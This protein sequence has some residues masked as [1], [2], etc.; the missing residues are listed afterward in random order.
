VVEA[1]GKKKA[2]A[3]PRV[4]KTEDQAT[5]VVT[6]SEDWGMVTDRR[7]CRKGAARP[8]ATVL[9]PE[10]F[11]EPGDIS[12]SELEW[13]RMLRDFFVRAGAA[14]IDRPELAGNARNCQSHML[15]A[16]GGLMAR[17]CFSWRDALLLFASGAS[18]GEV[19][20]RQKFEQAVRAHRG[21]RKQTGPVWPR[22]F[23]DWIEKGRPDWDKQEIAEAYARAGGVAGKPESLRVYFR[24]HR[25]KS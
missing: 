20:Y 21:S 17:G 2:T 12:G 7:E 14:Q 5:G 16:L 8:P 10:L 3:W 25:P 9:P 24:K 22:V 19:C 13:Y 11:P 15:S 23:R 18:W 6:T 1:M 4:T